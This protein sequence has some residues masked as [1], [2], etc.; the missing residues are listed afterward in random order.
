M[1]IAWIYLDP[2]NRDWSMI[3][4]YRSLAFTQARI[5]AQGVFSQMAQDYNSKQKIEGL[6][7]F[8]A[9]I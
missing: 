8:K 9:K 2:K 7:E 5:L 1:N 4:L 3:T 6:I